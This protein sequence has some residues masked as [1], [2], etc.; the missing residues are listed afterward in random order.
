MPT[1]DNVIAGLPQCKYCGRYNDITEWPGDMAEAYTPHCCYA[2]FLED[3]S[4][5]ESED[6]QPDDDDDGFDP[7]EDEEEEIGD[8]SESDD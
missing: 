4:R 7:E 5:A 1:E 6:D 8:D 2:C 3:P